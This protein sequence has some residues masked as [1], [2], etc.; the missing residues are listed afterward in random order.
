[1]S[2]Y[3]YQ[4]RTHGAHARKHS[5]L[6]CRGNRV[7]RNPVVRTHPDQTRRKACERYQRGNHQQVSQEDR[8]AYYRTC[9]WCNYEQIC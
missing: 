5:A 9:A 6:H 4:N 2:V 7:L 8:K 3:Q 1:M